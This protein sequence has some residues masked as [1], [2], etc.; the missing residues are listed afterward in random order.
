MPSAL[1]RWRRNQFTIAVLNPTPIVELIP[2]ETSENDRNSIHSACMNASDMIPRPMHTTPAIATGLAP[3]RSTKAPMSGPTAPPTGC[4]NSAVSEPT[5]RLQ[6][7][8]SRMGTKST[9]KP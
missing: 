9:P 6:P 7:K 1:P 3:C 4:M 2:I 8:V 5:L